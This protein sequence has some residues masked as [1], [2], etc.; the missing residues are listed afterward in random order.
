M[1]HPLLADLPKKQQ[2]QLLNDLN[3]LNT[4]EIKQFCKKHSIPYSIAIEIP[5]GG[6]K[7]TRDDDRKGV[8]L[9]RMRHFLKT[10]VALEETRFPA[11]VV[12]LD[13]FPK[14]LTPNHKLLYGQY[15]KNN[16]AMLSLLK[17]L[18]AGQFEDGAIAR[19][20]A[21]NYWTEG[22]APT[23][24]K[25]ASAWLKAVQAHTGPNPEWAFLSDRANKTA[26]PDWK[27]FRADKA[28]KV[29]RI[30]NQIKPNKP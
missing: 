27:R 20:L 10:G 25:F 15:S 21:R 30:L 6:K 17:L 7:K 26:P 29:M 3:Y 4:A 8:M 9:D 18:T 23:L 24:E 22:K 12:C 16:R 19:I 13:A 1:S 11:A 14:K 28:S 2:Q 5:G